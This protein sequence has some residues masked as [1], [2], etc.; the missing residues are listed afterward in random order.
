MPATRED[1]PEAGRGPVMIIGA[2]RAG[3]SLACALAWA[4]VPVRL[5]GRRPIPEVCAA[6]PGI[7]ADAARPGPA[8]VVTHDPAGALPADVARA[9]V[10]ILAVRDEQ[11]GGL[12]SSLAA[13]ALAPGAVVLQLS[14]AAE[15]PEL[16]GSLGGGRAAVGTFHPLIPLMPSSPP[17]VFRGAWV[18]VE[19]DAEAVLAAEELAGRLGAN[20]LRIPSGGRAA[21]H[22]A[23][24]LASNFPVVLA[25]LAR[26][27]LRDA[28]VEPGAADGAVR[29]LLAAAVE[30]VGR[31]TLEPGEVAARLT[32]PV[33]RGDAATIAAHRRA[34]AD[35][36]ATLAVYDV[37]TRAAVE[38]VRAGGGEPARLAP[39]TA[40]LPPPGPPG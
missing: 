24:V 9:R 30:N 29:A 15:L 4:G 1:S 7:D 21:Y 22:A 6:A 11:L 19:G 5:H 12:V 2:G 35:D 25:A 8:P 23:A 28:G 36:H 3:R 16:Q 13:S 17:S 34:L 18:G 37:L 27:L 38:L 14:G 31:G 26:G 32:G 33:A 40:L 10:L 20:T 39:I